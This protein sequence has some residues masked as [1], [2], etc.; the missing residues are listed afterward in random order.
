M[1]VIDDRA[2]QRERVGLIKLALRSKV[3][4][5]GMKHYGFDKLGGDSMATVD[6][7]DTGGG[8]ATTQEDTDGLHL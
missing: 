1:Y 7:R 6:V 3:G 2:S 8:I 4:E 5:G